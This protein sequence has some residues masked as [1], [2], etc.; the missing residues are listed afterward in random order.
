MTVGPTPPDR[1]RTPRWVKIFGAVAVLLIVAFA[2]LHLAGGG[3][4]HQHFPADRASQP[5]QP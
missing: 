4:R 5:K 1:Y 3:F 2:V